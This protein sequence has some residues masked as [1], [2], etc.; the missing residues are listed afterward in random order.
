MKHGGYRE[1]LEILNLC[2]KNL[3]FFFGNRNLLEADLLSLWDYREQYIVEHA[4]RK[5]KSPT[6]IAIRIKTSPKSKIL[7]KIT[8][9]GGI[10][11]KLIKKLGFKSLIQ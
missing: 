1:T 5:I 6:S 9:P 10:S 7:W 2:G 4:F 3:H 11:S 8:D